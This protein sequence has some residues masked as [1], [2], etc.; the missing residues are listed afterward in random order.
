MKHFGP[1]LYLLGIERIIFPALSE[2]K[3]DIFL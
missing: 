3:D 2:E 1:V